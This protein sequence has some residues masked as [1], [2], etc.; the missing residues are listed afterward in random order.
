MHLIRFSALLCCLAFALPAHAQLIEAS[1]G[2]LDLQIEAQ[3]PA[4]QAP[5]NPVFLPPASQES[6]VDIAKVIDA[7]R[8][9]KKMNELRAVTVDPSGKNY[10]FYFASAQKGLFAVYRNGRVMQQGDI[11]SVHDMQAPVVFRMTASGD[12]LYAL[13]NTDLYVNHTQVSADQFSFSKG[14]TSVHDEGGILTFPEGGNVVT[15]DI[16]RDR[17]AVLYKHLGSIEYMRRRGDAVAYA[18]RE[19]GF[20]RMYK[21]GRRVSVKPVDNPENFAIGPEGAVYFFTKAARG[22]SLY[23]DTR[24]YV[25]G[26]GAGAYV[27]LDPEGHVWHLAYTRVEHATSVRLLKDRSPKNLLPSGIQNVELLLY[28]PRPGSFALRATYADADKF[29]MT[30]ASGIHGMTFVFEYPYND[31]NGFVSWDGWATMR[32][33]DGNRW[34][35]YAHGEPLAHATLK[36]VWFVR[37]DGDQLTIY[38]TR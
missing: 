10:G 24:S 6:W 34:R 28:F 30:D 38:A 13:H 8:I 15:Y 25:T 12:L 3:P 7:Y 16:K 33:Y 20:V 9:P 4:P 31:T 36:N 11:E 1:T 22:Y 17:R 14:A 26:E 32:A 18:L 23:R 19:R 5:S 37:T 21:N 2:A 35:A 29:Y 27:A